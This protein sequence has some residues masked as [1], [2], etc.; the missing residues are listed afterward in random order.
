MYFNYTLLSS[1][2][3]YAYVRISVVLK[4]R[5]FSNQLGY[6]YFLPR[7]LRGFGLKG[8]VQMNKPKV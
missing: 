1:K 6:G 5:V 4:A 8:L 3:C 2:S 7:W